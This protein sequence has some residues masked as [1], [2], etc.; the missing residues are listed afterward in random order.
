MKATVLTIATV[1]AAGFFSLG[2]SVANAGPKQHRSDQMLINENEERYV[3]IAGSH[4]PQK[5]KLRS[6]G[7]NTPYNVRI[8]TQRELLSTGRQTPGEALSVLDPSIT[9]TGRH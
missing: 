4:I 2:S 7:T 3:Y 8:Y 6:I 1:I 5:V 9:L